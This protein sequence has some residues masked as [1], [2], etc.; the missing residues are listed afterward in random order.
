ML[1]TLPV[2]GGGAGMVESRDWE[3]GDRGGE[4]ESSLT[5]SRGCNFKG[6]FLEFRW[7]GGFIG[8]NEE[9]RNEV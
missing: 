8:R 5:E 7:L 2:T 6:T 3:V 4:E 9:D 1:G